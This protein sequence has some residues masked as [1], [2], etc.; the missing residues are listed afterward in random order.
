MKNRDIH[1]VN[2]IISVYERSKLAADYILDSI[3]SF[4][5]IIDQNGVIYRANY[6]A[7]ELFNIQHE[8]LPGH[9]LK[10]L[11]EFEQYQIFQNQFNIIKNRS[12]KSV[13]FD[14]LINK[15]NDTKT[16]LWEI[17][18]LDIPIHNLSLYKINGSDVTAFKK[19]IEEYVNNKNEVEILKKKNTRLKL[20][21]SIQD[22]NSEK[23]IDNYIRE[24]MSLI[25]NELGFSAA[26]FWRYDLTQDSLYPEVIDSPDTVNK[27]QSLKT[28]FDLKENHESAF[29]SFKKKKAVWDDSLSIRSGQ[30][31]YAPH[32]GFAPRSSITTLVMKGQNIYGII[33][34][35]TRQNRAYEENIFE[36]LSEVSTRLSD[37]VY[38][39]E[40]IDELNDK[41]KKLLNS[42]KMSALGEMSGS[43]AH[44][45]NNPLAI[46]VGNINYCIKN[47]KTATIDNENLLARL[48]TTLRTIGR[49]T[50]IIKGLKAFS[51][52]SDLDPFKI[53]SIR[54]VV[55]E[56]LEICTDR[57]RLS[58]VDLLVNEVS[59]ILFD[60]RDTQIIQVLVNMLNNAFDAV[61]TLEEKWVKLEVF[62]LIEEIKIEITDS[63]TGIPQEIA[64]K[65]MQPFFTTKETGKGTGLGLSIS[66]GIIKN[67]CGQFFLDTA[68]KNTKFVIILRKKI[69]LPILKISA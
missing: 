59:P 24:N 1:L 55:E 36:T 8:Y 19:R 37:Q 41:D 27:I 62:D 42:A 21:L 52:N 60:C 43:I 10:D 67:H 18:R 68:S 61:L 54:Q 23:G 46:I 53:A 49:I 50:K 32:V 16:Y 69:E 56:T 65:I 17:D 20:L 63:G 5:V 14:L 57:F 3:S 7:A 30:S 48:E 38:K 2:E 15:Q 31:F 22:L 6:H 66:L 34:F 26:I 12:I 29:Y 13:Q 44:E 9:L 28:R 35:L 45:I 25:R 58:K 11:L 33:E 64:E 4:F 51:R 39:Q 47:L 40:L